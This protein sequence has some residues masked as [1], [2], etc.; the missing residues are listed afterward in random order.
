VIGLSILKVIVSKLYKLCPLLKVIVQV[1]QALSNS[2]EPHQRPDT[3][4]GAQLELVMNMLPQ[5]PKEICSLTSTKSCCATVSE[6][7]P[8][9][10]KVFFFLKIIR[11]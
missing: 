10:S 8:P 1:V 11:A 9:C 4:I 6:V 2:L 3:D 5:T 7:R